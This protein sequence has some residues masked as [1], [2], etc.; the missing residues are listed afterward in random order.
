[1]KI[2][3]DEN[4]PLVA[5]YFGQNAELVL[6]SGRSITRDDVSAADILLVRSVTKVDRLLLHDTSIKFVG[7]T[8]AG[9]DHLDTEYMDQNGI[10]WSIAAGC[11]A[12]AVAE[13]VVCVVAVLQKKELLQR[14]RLRAGVIG[15]G[16]VGRLVVEKLIALGFD[17]VQCDPFRAEIES[18]FSHTDIADFHNLDFISI[19]VPLT[20]HGKHPSFHLIDKNFLQ[21][22]K[23]NCI[24]L[25]AGRG[26]VI[27]FA[28]LKMHGNHLIWCL[29]VWENE[30][31]IDLEILSSAFIATPHIAG[32]SVQSKYRGI[33]MIYHA[34]VEKNILPSSHVIS[35]VKYPEKSIVMSEN[36][37]TWQDVALEIFNPLTVTEWM[38]ENILTQS[39]SFDELRKT[40]PERHEF[41][42]VNKKRGA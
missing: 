10:A 34:A 7:S 8:T 42:F 28:D 27:S 4:I 38:K 31:Q 21:R 37:I 18:D 1:V 30:P 5:H 33:E 13:Y 25:N 14:P 23:Q 19:H 15:V 12:E 24:L 3:A 22:Q 2:V 17:V 26:E 39:R 36:K 29:D 16:H 6:K 35:D 41:A 20:H 9:A 11:N 40:F 32:Y